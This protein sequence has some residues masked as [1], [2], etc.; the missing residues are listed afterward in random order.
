ME[1]SEKLSF[2]CK[3]CSDLCA[4]VLTG[5]GPLG[6]PLPPHFPGCSQELPPHHLQQSRAVQKSKH[7]VLIELTPSTKAAGYQ[8][9]NFL[10]EA[11]DQIFQ[12][13][14]PKPGGD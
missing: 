10:P 7:F 8:S 3:A 4:H 11:E 13:D 14:F 9:A 1:E 5:V 2:S 12:S 6:S